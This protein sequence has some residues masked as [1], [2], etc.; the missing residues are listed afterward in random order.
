VAKRFLNESSFDLM[1]RLEEFARS[2]GHTLLEL[3]LSWLVQ[4]PQV[5]SVL[6]GAT[7]PEQVRA[8]VKAGGWTLSAEELNAV[9]DLTNQTVKDAPWRGDSP[10]ATRWA[11]FLSSF[12]G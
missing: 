5:S 7:K 4:Q 2:R 11:R 8:N 12:K 9:N 6:V 1:E 10:V 3:A